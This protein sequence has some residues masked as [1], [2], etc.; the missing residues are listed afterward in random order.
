MSNEHKKFQEE[1]NRATAERVRSS[2]RSLIATQV[3]NVNF[4]STIGSLAKYRA[5]DDWDIYEKHL[6]RYFVANKVPEN[7]RVAALITLDG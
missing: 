4:F 1:R 7:R 3:P 5:G 2:S 6:N